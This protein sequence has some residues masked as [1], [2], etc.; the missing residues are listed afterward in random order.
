MV[1]DHF[2]SALFHNPS[3]TPT[4]LLCSLAPLSSPLS[5]GWGLLALAKPW[6]SHPDSH[7]QR[8]LEGQQAGVSAAQH[9][10]GWTCRLCAG[11]GWTPSLGSFPNHQCAF[12]IILI[13]LQIFFCVRGPVFLAKGQSSTQCLIH[14]TQHSKV[15]QR[16]SLYSDDEI[17]F[18][19]CSIFFFLVEFI[20][21]P[22]L[23][24]LLLKSPEEGGLLVQE[25]TG[26][27]LLKSLD[28]AVQKPTSYAS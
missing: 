10:Q 18:S 5:R 12:Y 6:Y 26:D 13:Y 4:P 14:A 2:K 25:V 15:Q 23:Q 22:L 9:E 3:D 17:A 1:S 28:V 27:L 24:Q 21:A 8:L 11:K 20:S 7:S 16:N 19:I